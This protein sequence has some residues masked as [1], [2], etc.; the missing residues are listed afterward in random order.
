MM[1]LLDRATFAARVLSTD[2]RLHGRKFVTIEFVLAGVLAMAIGLAVGLAAI[3][4][5][6]DGIAPVAGVVF[7]A[8]VAV[9]SAAV[10]RW[11]GRHPD[12]VTPAQASLLDLGTFCVSTLIPGV[13]AFSLR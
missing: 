12:G 13:L 6:K 5:G 11:V 7:F 2:L 10:V 4:R 9:N 8:G 3:V 1:D